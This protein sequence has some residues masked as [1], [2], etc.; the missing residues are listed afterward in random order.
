MLCE[1]I[2]IYVYAGIVLEARHRDYFNAFDIFKS[3]PTTKVAWLMDCIKLGI[4][5]NLDRKFTEHLPLGRRYI[6]HML[7]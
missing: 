3:F 2:Y 1:Y 5:E 7:P 4:R 6:K